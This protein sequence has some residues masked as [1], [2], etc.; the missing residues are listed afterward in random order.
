MGVLICNE[1]AKP[2]H[3]VMQKNSV[4]KAASLE[5]NPLK[6]DFGVTEM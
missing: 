1:G 2:N 3:H 6:V 4:S 5:V